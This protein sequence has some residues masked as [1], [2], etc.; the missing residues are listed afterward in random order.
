ML[1]NEDTAKPQ[2]IGLIVFLF[3]IIAQQIDIVQN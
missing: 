2:F 1:I 3:L